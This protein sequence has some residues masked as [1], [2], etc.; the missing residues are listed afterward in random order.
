VGPY[1]PGL[2][3]LE[4]A[5]KIRRR[6]LLSFE[7]AEER[8][9]YR[10]R[11]VMSIRVRAFRPFVGGLFLSGCA[12]IASAANVAA[13]AAPVEVTFASGERL[14]HGFVYKPESKG[15]FRAVL[16]NY[17]SERRPGWLPK[18]GPLLLLEGTSFLFPIDAGRA[19]RQG[20]SFRE[21]VFSQG[22]PADAVFS[23]V[24]IRLEQP[25]CSKG[26]GFRNEC[27]FRKLRPLPDL[28]W[29]IKELFVSGENT[30][31]VRGDATDY[32]DEEETPGSSERP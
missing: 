4:D 21:I 3:T 27:R 32:I 29:T 11:S 16:W 17:G 1:A 10:R 20:T 13:P 25:W 22:D 19:V 15:P 8:G 14:L 31:I 28:N 2:K 18:L 23:S 5:T 12:G 7:L 9:N 26:Q 6:V 30:I 24:M